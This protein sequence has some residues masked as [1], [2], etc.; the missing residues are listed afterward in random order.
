[1]VTGTGAVQ[2]RQSPEEMALCGME[3]RKDKRNRKGV[4][5]E[6]TGHSIL[7]WIHCLQINLNVDVTFDRTNET[8]RNK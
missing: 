4:V 6:K 5:S 3:S 1:M 8:F 2:D 7:R